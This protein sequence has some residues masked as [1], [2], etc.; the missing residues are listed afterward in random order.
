MTDEIPELSEGQRMRQRI[1]RG[2]G[3]SMFTDLDPESREGAFRQWQQTN[4]VWRETRDSLNTPEDAGEHAAGLAAI[5]RRIPDGRGR[6]I[7]VDAGWYPLI[8]ELDSVLAELDPGYVVQQVKEKFGRLAYYVGSD[9]FIGFDNPFH[10]A[11]QAAQGR[12]VTICEQCGERGQLCETGP[13]GPPGRWVK[14]LCR[15]HAAAGYRGRI[16]TPVKEG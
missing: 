11:K 14:T 10:R 16:Y 3:G 13:M 2:A 15:E 8:C 6:W 1:A 7:G 9:R 4:G 5:L 12:S